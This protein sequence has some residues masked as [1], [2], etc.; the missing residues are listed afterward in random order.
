MYVNIPILITVTPTVFEHVFT[1][2]QE[3]VMYMCIEDLVSIL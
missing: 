1:I 3:G 2:V